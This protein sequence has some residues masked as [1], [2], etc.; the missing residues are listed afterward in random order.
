MELVHI[1][2]GLS[3]IPGL[4]LGVTILEKTYARI[5]AVKI[6]KQQCRDLNKRCVD[7]QV[8]LQESLQGIEGSRASMIA[9]ELDPIIHRMHRKVA[10]WATWGQLKSFLQQREIKDGI[11]RLNRDLD[12]AM[13]KFHV[14][15]HMETN[16][17][18][19]D[20][21]AAQERDAVEIRELLFTIVK[22][23]ADMRTL[24]SMQNPLAVEEMMEGLQT[25]LREYDLPQ[26]EQQTFKEGLWTLHEKTSQLP[27]LTDLSG[28]ITMASQFPVREGSSNDIYQG[29]W[30]DQEDVALRLPRALTSNTV[31]RDRFEREV[32]IWKQLHHDNVMKLYGFVYLDES[33]YL[34]SPWMENGT[35]LDFARSNIHVD[36]PKL[37]TEI[38]SGLD[39][40]HSKDIV[41]GDLR[42]ANVL[43]S[44]DG[45]AKLSDFGVS[46]FLEDCNEKPL[47]SSVTSIR[48]A[49]PEVLR[50]DG[51]ASTF[52][53]V[54]SFGMVCL[55]LLTGQAPFEGQDDATVIQLLKDAKTPERPG[56]M[57]TSRG[58]SP[59]MWDLMRKCW[60]SNPEARPS[61]ATVKSKL[62]E[63]RGLS[64][65]SDRKRTIGRISTIFS[66]PQ[67]SSRPSTAESTA[68][69]ST[70]GSAFQATS[71]S[72]TNGRPKFF[73]TIYSEP[74]ELLS[75]IVRQSSRESSQ[76]SWTTSSP[77]ESKRSPNITF[78]MT[79]ASTRSSPG[80]PYSRAMPV[81]SS[82]KSKGPPRL[83]LD[84]LGSMSTSLPNQLGLLGINGPS[85]N[86]TVKPMSS[87]RSTHSADA[88]MSSIEDAV[89][90]RLKTLNMS[91][92][93]VSSG[94]MKGL[95]DFL[96]TNFHTRKHRD[97]RD[98][99][100]LACSEFSTAEGLFD[101]LL[102]RFNQAESDPTLFTEDRVAIQY[103]I[104]TI[105]SELVD[106]R[107][108]PASEQ[109]LFTMRL[110]C[111][112]AMRI[113]SSSTMV[114]RAAQIKQQVDFQL[115]KHR[116]SMTS[117]RSIRRPLLQAADI[118]PRDLAIAL[119][120]LEGD[121]YA[122]LRPSDYLR[123]LTRKVSNNLRKAYE[124]N[125]KI[126]AYVVDSVLFYDKVEDRAQ[127]LK[128]FINTA[129]E[130]RNLRNFSS[131]TQIAAALHSAP[132]EN[133]KLTRKELT[134]QMQNKLDDLYDLVKPE[135]N[136]RGYRDALN[137]A[138]TPNERDY[139]VPFIAVHLKDLRKVLRE[140]E[141]TI[142]VDDHWLINYRRYLQIMD[143]MN[144]VF[145]YKAPQLEE[146]RNGG[147]LAYLENQLENITYDDRTQDKHLERS[148]KLAQKEANEHRSR[149]RQMRQ[150][151]F[152]V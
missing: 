135:S 12:A 71:T 9:D 76:S 137:N 1:A 73:S 39:Y 105:I 53:D 108:L 48:W 13:M 139:C 5:E 81:A 150:L 64:P 82:S 100:F 20:L 88:D 91:N 27:P 129:V 121:N 152:R 6:Y 126:F 60:S 43:V 101:R 46:K 19:L 68:S 29:L 78:A 131:A 14:Q 31:V 28:Q 114:D 95:V 45:T 56:R 79:P 94:T 138:R 11:E 122:A 147:Q 26:T 130:C 109:L 33:L 55:E 106:N 54:W 136:H 36:R 93:Q 132:V 49:A 99:F 119:T 25:Q 97:F 112:H 3:G 83:E 87:T 143:R 77:T 52:S 118:R 57:V 62:L 124:T 140:Q 107:D 98:A 17:S 134:V 15:S 127:V 102:D 120:L 133:L 146:Y 74:D 67:K 7:L 65:A 4:E 69:L 58:L 2:T 104:F 51:I 41:H 84:I 123:H 35:I 75:P 16:R 23:T 72:P 144:E 22:S 42:G 21:R 116:R 113:K 38:A 80:Q 115:A 24:M 37:L 96:I 32:A 128:M 10:D 125:N 30:L 145:H 18:H 111:E 89:N 61:M 142:R 149:A 66:S 103:N 92:E 151:G 86:D 148:S 63:M 59:D 117:P 40:L 70:L 47:S 44:K 8:A 90:S 34:V 110:F 50:D 141:V 85:R